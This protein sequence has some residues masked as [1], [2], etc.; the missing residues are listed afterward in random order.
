LLPQPQIPSLKLGPFTV[1]PFGA[2]V[3]AGVTLGF[4]L[5][6][7]RAEEL[8]LDPRVARGVR[9]WAVVPGFVAAHLFDVLFYTPER[10]A[11][12]PLLLLRIWDGISSFGGFAGGAA[13][14][15][16]YLVHV[17][18]VPVRPYADALAYAFTA[19]WILGR[20]GCTVAYDHP[21]IRTDFVL[22]MPYTGA[23]VGP[24]LRHNLGFYEML[25]T[26]G[27][28]AW[29]WRERRRPHR[30]GFYVSVA[31][32]TY[33]PF[34]FLLDFLRDGEIRFAGLTAGQYAAVAFFLL[35]LRLYTGGWPAVERA[36]LLIASVIA[37]PVTAEGRRA[38]SAS[39]VPEIW[40][41]TVSPGD[42][43]PS[44]F[45]HTALWVR[46]R[47]TGHER[48]YNYGLF[49]FGP[50][51]L[52]QFLT[53]RLWFWV[54]ALPPR[55]AFER[56]RSRD[57][58]VRVQRLRLGD[59]RVAELVRFLEWNVRPENR[60]Y[61]YDHYF[62]NCT[63]RVRDLLDGAIEGE[64]SRTSQRPARFT[65]R[66]H[67]RRHIQR[68]PYMDVVLN[69]WMSRRID[70]PIT[71]WDEMFLP[72]ELERAID[73]VSIGTPNG[74]TAPL[75]AER[76]VLN[77]SR[78][79]AVPESPNRG[80]YY[81]AAAAV[82]TAGLVAAVRARSHAA[83]RRPWRITL[84]MLHVLVGGIL[85]LPGLVVVMAWFTDHT[86]AHWNLNV[87]YANP[88]TFA[89]L[90]I[91]L[92]MVAGSERARRWSERGWL[93]LGATTLAGL[94]LELL[95]GLEQANGEILASYGVLNL[96]LAGDVALRRPER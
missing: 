69:L 50:A 27:L 53:G 2:F 25:W 15:I 80:R 70:R 94:T 83:G 92:G 81:Y 65:L 96:M 45:G 28:F 21:G 91:G 38:D 68:S 3:A 9:L 90:P 75:V 86:I 34:R 14:A 85:G 30:P 74:G 60:R 56:Y 31:L 47:T 58:E 18:R 88:V 4:W 43:I 11:G 48:L 29:F 12:D 35:G 42:D 61:L 17:A 36:S 39:P 63:T 76:Q 41:V 10:L 6:V 23:L 95:P 19:A 73:A 33:T 46:D 20:L 40:L 1:E 37:A 79:E 8:G 32:L 57:R 87:C 49:D 59:E 78:R 89:M 52:P 66:G 64:L 22:A 84:G 44:W 55:A 51:M 7:K 82:A 93:F 16:Y 62:D 67:T 54:G 72:A 5:T 71:R 13:G 77:R 26:V 24:G